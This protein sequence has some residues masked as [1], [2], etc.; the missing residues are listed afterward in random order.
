ML[1]CTIYERIQ[2]NLIV[3]FK[4]NR[5]KHHAFASS[6]ICQMAH[7]ITVCSLASDKKI[8]H[9]HGRSHL[10]FPLHVGKEKSMEK[11]IY[12]M[13]WLYFHYVKTLYFK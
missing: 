9:F 3:N 5:A 11:Y 4:E 7:P 2:M 10:V 13:S 6:N 12:F 8:R 1:L